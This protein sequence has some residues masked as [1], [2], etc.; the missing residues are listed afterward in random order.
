LLFNLRRDPFERA[1]H[2]ANTYNDW[3]LS[4]AFV[5]LQSERGQGTDQEIPRLALTQPD[6]ATMIIAA[7]TQSNAR[8]REWQCH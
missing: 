5:L 3:F 4:R 1:Q 8:Q 7:N 6:V 2:N